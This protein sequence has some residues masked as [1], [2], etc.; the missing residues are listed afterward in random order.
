VAATNLSLRVVSPAATVFEGDVE[1]V[2]LPAWDGEVGILPGHAPFISLLGGGT[3]RARQV[4]GGEFQRFLNRGVVKVENN[5]V[6][7]LSEYAGT[8]PPQGFSPSDAWLDLDESEGGGEGGSTV[9][10]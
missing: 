5:Q 6:T 3:M 1:S 9:L 2:V 7:V 4:G 10:G 8:E